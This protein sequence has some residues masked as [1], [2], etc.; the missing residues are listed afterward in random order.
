[1]QGSVSDDG[2]PNPPRRVTTTWSK[3]SGPGE[4]SFADRNAAST[5]ASFSEVGTYVLRLTA[6]DSQLQGTDDV[7]VVF[8]GGGCK[9]AVEGTVTYAI[10]GQYGFA[11]GARVEALRDGIVYARATAGP[12][13]VYQRLTMPCGQ[14]TVRAHYKGYYGEMGVW[15]RDDYPYLFVNIS[16]LVQDL[17]T[18]A[19]MLSEMAADLLSQP[20]S[21]AAPARLSDGNVVLRFSGWASTEYE[22]QRSVNL[23]NWVPWTNLVCTAPTSQVVDAEAPATSNRFYRLK[24]VE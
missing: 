8:A 20:A 3:L 19:M 5:R 4:L 7:Q 12:D 14:Y 22:V 6:S 9:P 13:G 11:S 17:P 1:L 18:T 2:L 10:N 16:I 24:Q 21:L 23:L 15:L